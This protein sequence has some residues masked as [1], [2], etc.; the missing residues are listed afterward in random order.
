MNKSRGV[1][2]TLP[3]DAIV[4]RMQKHGDQLLEN[5][6]GRQRGEFLENL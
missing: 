5:F 1:S 6:T 4:D 2:L 3:C